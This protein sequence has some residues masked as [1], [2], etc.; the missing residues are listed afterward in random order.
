MAEDTSD[1][2]AGHWAWIRCYVFGL[3]L[4]AVAACYGIV[5][6][7]IGETYLPGLAGN[8]PTLSDQTGTALA[9]GYLAA[10]LFL[11]LRLYLEERVSSEEG[12]KNLYFA[13]N[14]LLIALIAC[15]G[16]VLLHVGS[17]H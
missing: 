12:W 15:L 14:V 3:G 7:I 5:A 4:G 1:K 6:L 11:L 13:Q 10:G 9:G 16:Y 8:D 17:A 2:P